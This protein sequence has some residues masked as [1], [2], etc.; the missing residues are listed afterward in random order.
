[1]SSNNTDSSAVEHISSV[2]NSYLK[3]ENEIKELNRAIKQRRVKMA[4]LEEV[5]LTF[6]DKE[7]DI[8]SIKI[9]GDKEIVAVKKD[10]VKQ[11]SRKGVIDIMETHLKSHEHLLNKIKTDMNNKSETVTKENI[12]FRKVKTA[13]TTKTSS[14]LADELLARK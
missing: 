3:L 2:I 4:N 11:V 5:I 1:M 8:D 14:T 12:K 9:S 13:N 6:M 7:A 10:H